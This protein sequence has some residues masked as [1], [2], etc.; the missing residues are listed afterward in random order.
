MKAVI[1]GGSVGGLFAANM[2]RARGWDVQVCERVSGAMESRG[3]GIAGHEELTRLMREAG[4]DAPARGI[5][6]DGRVAYGRDGRVL[7]RYPYPQYLTSWSFVFRRLLEALPPGRYRLG[8]ELATLE[9][10]GRRPVAVFADGRRIEADLI[11][12]ADGFRSRV[13]E[14]LAPQV[15]LRYAGYVAFRGVM[16]DSVLSEAFRSQRAGLFSFV[17]PGD[18]QLIGYPLLGPDDSSE[19]GRRRYGYLW[20][21]HTPEHELRDLLTDDGGAEH[22]YSIPPPLIRSEHIERLKHR[23]VTTLPSEFAEIVLR[24]EQHMFQPIYDVC[25]ER[26]AFGPVALLGDAAF[27]A[28]P[29]VGIGVL[30]AAQD[31]G[32]LADSLDG[33]RPETVPAALRRYDAARV[34]PGRTAVAFAQHLGWFIERGLP[35]PWVDGGLGQAPDYIVRVSARPMEHIADDLR[36]AAIV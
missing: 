17:F 34:P 2:L 11:V 28:R 30:K 15:A 16:K 27:V 18:G 9:L 23:A 3:A 32:A 20:Y 33:C 22:R 1:V 7:A 4:V 14:L 36:K 13:R 8:S 19:P 5:L 26:I 12:G 29:H 10:D 31:A 24:A 35:S 6:V 21:L 25:S